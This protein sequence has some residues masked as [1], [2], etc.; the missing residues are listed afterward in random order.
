MCPAQIL[1]EANKAGT[2]RPSDFAGILSNSTGCQQEQQQQ[3]PKRPPLRGARGAATGPSSPASASLASSTEGTSSTGPSLSPIWRMSHFLGELHKTTIRNNTGSIALDISGMALSAPLTELL[4][5]ENMASGIRL[6]LPE[7]K[8]DNQSIELY[9]IHVIRNSLSPAAPLV[10]CCLRLCARNRQLRQQPCV[11]VC[12]VQP[13][14]ATG[15][16]PVQRPAACFTMPA[17]G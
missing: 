17:V 14:A 11:H 3:K 1:L 4:V 13:A 2:A 5:A 7:P 15:T 16:S 10:S 12:A 8:Y 9:D 6:L